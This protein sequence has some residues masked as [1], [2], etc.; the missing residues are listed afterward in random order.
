MAEVIDSFEKV[1]ILVHLH[2]VGFAPRTA[3]EIAKGLAISLPAEEIE[4][5]L[6]AMRPTG[7]LEP[8]GPWAAAVAELV[9]MYRRDRI[10]VMH[11]IT[12]SALDRV[13]RETAQAARTFADAFVLRPKKKGDP[14]A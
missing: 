11:L 10:E 4:Q 13:R 6:R 1:E 7:V 3:A 9:E 14:D 2:G 8:D 5:N 12:K